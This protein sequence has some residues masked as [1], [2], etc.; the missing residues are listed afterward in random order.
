MAL[1]LLQIVTNFCNR[2]NIPAPTSVIASTDTRVLQILRLLEEEGND[3][4]MRGDWNVLTLQAIV[5]T[6]ATES[7]GQITTLA[8]GGYR[9]IINDTIWDDSGRLPIYPIDGPEWQAI[10]AMVP[11]GISPYR[12]RLRGG[13]LI[14]TPTPPAGLTWVFEYVS[15]AWILNG[16]NHVQYFVADTDTTLLP[17]DLVLMG[18]RWRYMREKGLEYA[19]LFRTYETQVQYNLSNERP[20]PR[21]NMS[22]CTDWR[23]PGIYVPAGNWIHP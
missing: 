3:L 16:V 20:R 8:P 9:K 13:E 19:E 4:S 7:Q 21:L 12:Y 17:D 1:T 18:L 6:T 5:T 11:S 10:K 2:S 22:G 23:R 14:S 15:K